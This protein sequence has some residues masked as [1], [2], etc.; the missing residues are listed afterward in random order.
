[1]KNRKYVVSSIA[2]SL[3]SSFVERDMISLLL[4]FVLLLPEPILQQSQSIVF[5]IP[6]LLAQTV[7]NLRSWLNQT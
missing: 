4:Y 1:M 5:Y 6:L 7:N 2:L 3:R